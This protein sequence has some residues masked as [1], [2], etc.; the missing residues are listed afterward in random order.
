MFFWWSCRRESGLPVLF[1]HHLSS[2]WFL[3][4]NRFYVI[5]FN[6]VT[7]QYK[8][9]WGKE[10]FIFNGYKKALCHI[11]LLRKKYNI[12]KN[13]IGENWEMSNS[14]FLLSVQ[15]RLV[16]QSFLTLCSPMDCSRPPCPSPTPRVHT[17][18]C[19]LSKWYHPTISSSVIPFSSRL[20][21]FS[22]SGAFQM[23]QFFTSGVQSIGVSA[24]TSVFPVNIQDWF[25]LGL[26]G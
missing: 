26:T 7:R 8:K 22:A 12:I 23:R 17:N 16:A 14:N 5:W 10:I 21:S 18:S 13:I 19:L 3:I 11:Y 1:L 24:S 15:F 6:K 4:F 2:A 25:P 9:A 20:Q